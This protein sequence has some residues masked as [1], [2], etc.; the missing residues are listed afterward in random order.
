VLPCSAV[1]KV[2]SQKQQEQ[3]S[4]SLISNKFVHASEPTR[5]EQ[6]FFLPFSSLLMM[7]FVCYR[8]QTSTRSKHS[9]R[10]SSSSSGGGAEW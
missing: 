9:E 10:D 4:I 3:L 8:L 7:T 6:L 2:C 5:V 1:T